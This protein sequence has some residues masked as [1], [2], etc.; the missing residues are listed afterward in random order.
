[1]ATELSQPQGTEPVAVNPPSP[2][3]P[4][5]DD[6]L[7][8]AP[9]SSSSPSPSL[10]SEIISGF[11]DLF[12]EFQDKQFSL[13]WRGSRDGFDGKRFHRI[14][15][16]HPNT[17]IVILDTN[18]NIFGG[19]TAVEWDFPARN[20]LL[21]K[22][23]DS[24]KS[25]LFTLK[26][27]HNFA[28]R[29]FGLKAGPFYGAICC[30]C[31]DGPSFCD[32][33]VSN[34]C[35]RNSD[36]CTSGFGNS[37]INDTGL[38]GTTFF[39]GSENFQV[40]EIEAF[41]IKDSEPPL[42]E[43]PDPVLDSQIISGFPEIFEE[44]RGWSFSLLLRG[45]R[46]S[47]LAHT[48]HRRCDGQPNTL[49]VILD[50]NGN[51]FGGFTTAKWE[52]PAQAETKRCKR[53]KDNFL[54]TLKNPHNVP[55]RKFG[56]EKYMKPSSIICDRQC[57]A[58]FHDL[59]VSDRCN[60]NRDSRVEHFG[61]TYINDTGLEGKRFFAGSP[62]FQVKEVEVFE[63][64]KLD[65]RAPPPAIQPSSQQP[66]DPSTR[67]F[68]SEII[69]DFP[70]IFSEFQGEQFSLLF[71]FT[72]HGFRD[73]RFPIHPA[74]HK[75]TL[76][77]ILDRQGNIFG[78]FT[79]VKIMQGCG[80]VR[81]DPNQQSFLFTLKNP[82]NV[83]AR[84]F[85]I[86]AEMK[87]QAFTCETKRCPTFGNGDL[88][89]FCDY[90][91]PRGSALKFGEV[92]NNDT[93]LDGATFFTG[94]REFEIEEMEV[95]EIPNF[96]PPGVNPELSSI[97]SAI[98]SDFPEI[99]AEFQ[100]MKFSLLWRGSRHGFGSKVF[101]RRCDGHK[102]TLTLILDTKA[103]IFG[104][105][106]PMEWKIPPKDGERSV[107]DAS[108]DSFLFTLKNPGKIPAGKFPLMYE[109]SHS[110][111]ICNSRI[112]P[113]FGRDLCVSDR[114]NSNTNSSIDLGNCY[115]DVT[116]LYGKAGFTGSNTFKVKEIEVFEITEFD[117]SSGVRKPD[118]D[119]CT[120]M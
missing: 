89:V 45:S 26:N 24:Q 98:I 94:S 101:H 110:A 47:F 23:D 61:Y 118:R 70:E 40:K 15:D 36:S 52:S 100:G 97:G 12:S 9:S 111:I 58:N 87:H 39:T 33:N 107:E 78:G 109:E 1:M 19:F 29:K 66:S 18:G 84:R 41:E 75:N 20:T 76:T 103:N 114:C 73:N 30:D 59:V 82:H 32:I 108:L 7:P 31:D 57:G 46:D 67:F 50:T 54:F 90:W 71:R 5:Q 16:A 95:F 21:Y 65:P 43:W 116:G 3:A 11:P 4:S 72:R 92:Y 49:T 113:K 14:C 117:P 22:R 25:F 27:P 34:L 69:S 60:E 83:P 35:Q 105:F 99:F 119:K 102:R 93:G 13:L 55:A 64:T 77:L 62:E 74:G 38:D 56:L 120:V 112:G 88:V 53:Q 6:A 115:L 17:L 51:I 8:P 91:N 80:F 104:G 96:L 2:D 28:A 63:L 44:F 79:P 85:A 37:Y 68:D 42:I 106:T 10:D 86:K 48:F 81:A